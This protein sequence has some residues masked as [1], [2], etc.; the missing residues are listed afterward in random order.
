LGSAAFSFLSKRAAWWT[1]LVGVHE[2]ASSAHLDATGKRLGAFTPRR[3]REEQAAAR[4]AS[5]ATSCRLF[6]R[7]RTG[8][9]TDSSTDCASTLTLALTACR[10]AGPPRRP[11]SDLVGAWTDRRCG[12]ARP[13]PSG[14]LTLLAASLPHDKSVASPH[15]VPPA[16]R[17]RASSPRTPL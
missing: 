1:A 12:L 16:A 13:P 4:T 11:G 15:L 3:P 2:H 17:C 7:L 9:P 10:R 14:A 6:L 8:L 5:L